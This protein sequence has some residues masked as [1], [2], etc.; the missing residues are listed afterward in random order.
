MKIPNVQNRT[1]LADGTCSAK[2]FKGLSFEGRSSIPHGGV[3]NN[4]KPEKKQCPK[5]PLK[6]S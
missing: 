3:P 1:P 4:R 5:N 6:K 2:P